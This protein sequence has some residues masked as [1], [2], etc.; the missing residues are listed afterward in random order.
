MTA[1]DEVRK[2]VQESVDIKA[3]TQEIISTLEYFSTNPKSEMKPRGPSIGPV[4]RLEDTL[5]TNIM[6]KH[7]LIAQHNYDHP[8]CTLS[9]SGISLY[10]LL[11]EEGY[12]QR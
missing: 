1:E 9:L 7:G 12:I 6:L 3:I 5:A 11:K 10:K 8:M 2:L 4:V